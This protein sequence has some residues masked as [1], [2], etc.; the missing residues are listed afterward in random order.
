MTIFKRLPFYGSAEGIIW[1][2]ETGQADAVTASDSQS[3]VYS[4]RSAF[5]FFGS[6]AN[7]KVFA[8]IRPI[9]RTKKGITLNV[10]IDTDFK[11]ATT[12]TGV[13]TS[14]GTFTPWG[15][16]WGSSWSADLEYIFDRFATQG[17]GHCAAY[18]F[19]GSLKNATMQIL[20]M[21][22]RFNLGGQV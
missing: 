7:Y 11:R 12:V 19:G 13:T 20:G 1:Q 21:E 17:Q 4:G 16:P 10:G 14:P 5:S 3:I 22:I 9:V 18:R 8:D 2:G 15:S 6:R